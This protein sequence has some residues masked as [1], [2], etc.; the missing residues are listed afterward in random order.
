MSDTG[1]CQAALMRWPHNHKETTPMSDQVLRDVQGIRWTAHDEQGAEL[2]VADGDGGMSGLT[3]SELESMRGPTREET[4][5]ERLVVLAEAVIAAQR[6]YENTSSQ[7]RVAYEIAGVVLDNT[8][9]EFKAAATP[10]AIVGLAREL[11]AAGYEA[12]YQACREVMD[13]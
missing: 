12:G 6:I 11:T 9:A 1:T 3:R 10:Q 7:H 2:W 4:A 8:A 13:D 5:G